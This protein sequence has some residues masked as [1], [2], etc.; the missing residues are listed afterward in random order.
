MIGCTCNF[1]YYNAADPRDHFE[2]E[3]HDKSHGCICEWGWRG[4]IDGYNRRIEEKANCPYHK[5]MY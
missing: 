3:F 5:V 4:G 1:E 2:E